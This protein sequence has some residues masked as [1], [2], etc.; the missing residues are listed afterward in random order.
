M[1]WGIVRFRKL[2]GQISQPVELFGCSSCFLFWQLAQTTVL[3]K[4]F[5]SNKIEK[6]KFCVYFEDWIYHGRSLSCRRVVTRTCQAK[7][8]L[9][10]LQVT[11]P[12][13]LMFSLCLETTVRGGFRHD[14]TV[15]SLV[16]MYSAHCNLRQEDASYA[17]NFAKN[18]FKCP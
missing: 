3:A 4:W 1:K 5:V 17:S 7:S 11:A 18:T 8:A 6:I 2:V 15:R 14:F 16:C 10:C 12:N 13:F 9:Q